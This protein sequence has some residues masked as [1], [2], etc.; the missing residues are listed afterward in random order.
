MKREWFIWL[1]LLPCLLQAQTMTDLQ[2]FSSLDILGTARYIGL[3]GA[4]VALGGDPSAAQDNPAA[5]GVYRRSEISASTDV[6]AV[7]ST[8]GNQRA[9]TNGVAVSQ[10]SWNFYIP[11]SF[12]RQRGLIGHSLMLSYHR[13]AD[14]R[15]ALSLSQEGRGQYALLTFD[16]FGRTDYYSMVWGMN[17]SNRFYWGIGAGLISVVASQW[18]QMT[19]QPDS[20]PITSVRHSS[21]MNG[22]GVRL[23]TGVI[24]RAADWLR[25]GASFVSPAWTSTTFSESRSDETVTYSS[26]R[27]VMQ[28]LR[29]NAGL[30]FVIGRKALISMECDYA[31]PLLKK[32]SPIDYRL[33][34]TYLL[35]GGAEYVLLSNLFLNLGYACRLGGRWEYQPDLT[36][37][38][39]LASQSASTAISFRNRF[40]IFGLSYQFTWGT[41]SF[42]SNAYPENTFYAIPYARRQHLFTLTIAYHR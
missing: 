33:Q 32:V 40:M 13:L 8:A 29:V 42:S 22:L 35:K 14:Y 24:V 4:M 34:D 1:M 27:A 38:L 15:N 41:D 2:Q 9:R 21:T 16:S 10:A 5:V 3:G 31:H 7:R 30:A 18:H 20:A 19:Y 37:R 23:S 11:A 28:P 6:K 36:P 12:S 25:L 26:T 39:P 17:M